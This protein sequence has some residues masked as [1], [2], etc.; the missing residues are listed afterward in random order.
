MKNRVALIFTIIGLL[1][2]PSSSVFAYN[3]QTT[4]PALTQ[5]TAQYFNSLGGSLSAQQIEWMISGA[6]E[7]DVFPRWINHFYDPIHNLGWTGAGAG[8]LSPQTIQ[9]ARSIGISTDAPLSAP[10]WVTSYL[11]QQ[12]YSLYGGNRSWKR[13]LEYVADGNEQ[14]E[15]KTLGYILHLLQDMAV[16]DHT[17]DDT[18]AGA[19]GELTGDPGS[20]YENY[21]A[22]FN[23]TNIK[24]LKIPDYL[25]KIGLE[26][27]AYSSIEDYLKNLAIYSNKYFFSR[28]TINIPKYYEP[29]IVGVDS[30]YTYGVDENGKSL[31]L[32]SLINNTLEKKYYLDRDSNLVFQDYFIR[33]APK[34][35]QYGAGV[36]GLFL[37]QAEDEKINSEFRVSS[38]DT[39]GKIASK[40]VLPNISIGAAIDATFSFIGNSFSRLGAAVS[41]ATNLL[42]QKA[43]HAGTPASTNNQPTSQIAEISDIAGISKALFALADPIPPPVIQELS[44]KAD[45]SSDLI[46]GSGRN[47]LTIQTAATTGAN[48]APVVIKQ[49]QSVSRITELPQMQLPPTKPDTYTANI[50]SAPIISGG[51]V[52]V[53]V[54]S[55]GS[56]IDS[57]LISTTTETISPS[58]NPTTT[59]STVTSTTQ[60]N[61]N[62]QTSSLPIWQVSSSYN[63]TTFTLSLHWD[64]IEGAEFYDIAEIN[65]EYGASIIGTS[66]EILDTDFGRE[67]NFQILASDGER[68]IIASTTLRV[69]IPSLWEKAYFYQHP[70]DGPVLEFSYPNYPFI[71]SS[72]GASV[73]EGILAY[74]NADPTTGPSAISDYDGYNLGDASGTVVLGDGKPYIFAVDEGAC[75]GWG[76]G[77]RTRPCLPKED[78]RVRLKVAIPDGREPVEGDY[79][80]LAYYDLLYGRGGYYTFLRTGR[81]FKHIPFHSSVPEEFSPPKVPTPKNLVFNKQTAVLSFN[82]LPQEDSDSPDNELTVSWAFTEGAPGDADWHAADPNNSHISIAVTSSRQ[83]T[84][85]FIS[86]DSTGLTSSSSQV[87]RAPDGYVFLPRQEQ[88]GDMAWGADGLGQYFTV[89]ADADISGVSMRVR[90]TGSRWWMY[91]TSIAKIYTDSNGSHGELMGESDVHVVWGDEEDAIYTFTSPIHLVGNV[92]YWVAIET[93]PREDPNAYPVVIMGTQNAEAYPNGGFNSTSGPDARFWLIYPTEIAQPSQ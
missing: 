1:L 74:L 33:L 3:D 34:A 30:N 13:G 36:I 15:F 68:N 11:S 73:Y 90:K 67:R 84:I 70:S 83:F 87:W 41:S 53:V 26:I 49:T 69:F 31:R 42:L 5:E 7:E 80:T 43:G 71:P 24:E 10:E 88:Y 93:P 65:G 75:P 81:D 32:S 21:A 57:V 60:G 92:G 28:D 78:M 47:T 40:A 89:S 35:V 37:K 56:P 22:G 45:V 9:A 54:E 86:T 46:P 18:H 58:I 6:S 29:I 50:Q 20:P 17:R 61:E 12:A 52:A 85:S 23:R 55:L 44:T 2:S 25:K 82:V 79:L 4:H 16:P 39:L 48:L 27:P 59:T 51:S 38:R 66:L 76:A 77:L 62:P 63:K 14:E 72:G 64:P 91:G 8:N 19:V